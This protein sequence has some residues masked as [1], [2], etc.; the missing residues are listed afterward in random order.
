MRCM[1][2]RKA[3]I[4][5]KSHSELSCAAGRHPS[6]DSLAGFP[7]PSPRRVAP[8]SRGREKRLV[9]R[10]IGGSWEEFTHLENRREFVRVIFAHFWWRIFYNC[11]FLLL[12]ARVDS[13]FYSFYIQSI[14]EAF[15]AVV[16]M[17]QWFP[18][19]LS[20]QPPRPHYTQDISLVPAKM[21]FM[22]LKSI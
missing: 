7:S 16:V 5:A 22:Q 3:E 2:P 6:D 9:G 20:L 18:R 17:L 11:G 8:S 19:F 1:P 13:S 21:S 12:A 10:R 14:F 15:I 4:P